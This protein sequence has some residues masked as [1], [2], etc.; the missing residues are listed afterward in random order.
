M[1][2]KH[3]SAPGRAMRAGR[4]VTGTG[5][6][7]AAVATALLAPAMASAASVPGSAGTGGAASR[8]A[9]A[10]Y[11]PLWSIAK[12]AG[13]S[14]AADTGPARPTAPVAARVYLAG[15]NPRGLARYAAAVSDPRNERYGHYLTP[16]QVQRRFGP[17]RGQQ[18]AVRSWLES[19]GLRVIADTSH[20]IAVSG[21]AAEAA[22]AFGTRWHSFRVVKGLPQQ[23]NRVATTPQQAPVPPA[24]ITVPANVASAVLTVA[25]ME[26]KIPGYSAAGTA[27]VTS[28]RSR[29]S[30]PAATAAVPAGKPSPCSSY[31]GQRLATTLPKAY[32]RVAP[33]AACGYTPQQL[34]S[35]YG[36]PAGLT[37]AGVRTAVVGVAS[38]PTTPVDLATFARRHGQPLRPGQ[39][40]DMVRSG[41]AASCHTESA[42]FP[43]DFGDVE[44]VHAMAPGADLSYL[45]AKCDDDGQALP[46]L[47]DY[48]AIV[49]QHLASI[50]S[51]AWNAR[52]AEAT[53]SPGL[54]AAYEQVFMQGAAEGIGIY[55]DSDDEGDNASVSPAHRPTLS[56]P[57]ADPWVTAVGGTSLAIG[58]GGRYEW[59]TGWGDHQAK[60]A[61]SGRRWASLP[62]SFLG[63]GGGGASAVFQQPYYQRSVVPAALSHQHGSAAPMRVLPDIAADASSGTGILVG[64]KVSLSPGQPAAYHEFSFAGTS[65]SVQLI[66]GMQADAQQAAGH[67]LGF[68]NPA[69]YTRYGTADFH[70]VT[71]PHGRLDAVG[72]AGTPHPGTTIR[73]YLITM[74]LDQQ[75]TAAPGY[76]DTTGV[77]TP[78][79][80]YFA[81]YCR[82][83]DRGSGR[84]HGRGAGGCRLWSS[85]GP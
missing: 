41:L 68:A 19:A 18:Q 1:F 51:S 6:V 47:D 3:R 46:M 58:P 48:T 60:L 42:F 65:S 79:P 23:G 22:R 36:V 69:I 11:R 45:A 72:P 62:G 78:A 12:T 63:G 9:V 59:E 75:L 64:V 57:D 40:D 81:S 52:Y 24:K 34:R 5:V 67:P 85:T 61:S 21:T 17:A 15:R 54:I 70:D 50:V 20:Y 74:G 38:N 53:L 33:Y 37:G 35:A 25:P 66:A 7:A 71:A 39:F 16:A 82:S 2:R 29:T 28:T 26:T 44:L 43:E 10:A 55:V 84:D 80:P 14:A 83:R 76:D 13:G 31:F 77:G 49:D 30:T 73:P 27:P 56:Y 32:G 4:P 8:R